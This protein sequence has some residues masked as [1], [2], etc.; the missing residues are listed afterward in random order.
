[1]S[2]KKKILITTMKRSG[3]EINADKLITQSC[4]EIRMQDEITL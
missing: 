1:M 2:V 3:V 4:V